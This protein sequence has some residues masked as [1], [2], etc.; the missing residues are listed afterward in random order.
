MRQ[1]NPIRLD[2][3][4][5]RH[6]ARLRDMLKESYVIDVKNYFAHQ[7]QEIDWSGFVLAQM[8]VLIDTINV[9][10]F[11]KSDARVVLDAFFSSKADFNVDMEI[12]GLEL[13]ADKNSLDALHRLA[14]LY[15][16]G[17]KVEKNIKKT[18]HY[19]D[20]AVTLNSNAAMVRLG[21]MYA[22]GIVVDKD[23]KKSFNYFQLSA[24][25][26]D[27]FGQYNLGKLY[28]KYDLNEIND[29]E[30]IEDEFAE[31]RKTTLS[32]VWITLAAEQ[33]LANAQHD[34]AWSYHMDESFGIDYKIALFWYTLAA[35]QGFLD[36][37][38]NLGELFLNGQGVK[39]DCITAY[40]WFHIA[41]VNNDADALESLNELEKIL[42]SSE[43]EHALFQKQNWLSMHPIA[44][45]NIYGS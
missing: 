23:L 15:E 27:K 12:T 28:E 24:E 42:S 2:D 1:M 37:I 5:A 17:S 8:Q 40:K 34:L 26:G 16:V 19:L 33:G 3:D 20:R 44:K 41:S 21:I 31:L 6:A 30:Y 32:K 38:N 25:L 39:K 10:N 29:D 4:S 11:N 14:D 18:I 35:A 36:S 9:K 22:D 45:R 43:I 7:K 13:E